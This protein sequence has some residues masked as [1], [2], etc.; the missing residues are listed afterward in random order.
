[1][2]ASILLHL[3]SPVAAL[4]QAAR[5]TRGTMVVA[6]PWALGPERLHDNIMQIFPFGDSGRWTVWWQIS[7]GA[8]V[9]MLHTMGFR[10]AEVF[11]HTQ[12]HQFGHVV[13]AAYDDIHMYTVVAQRGD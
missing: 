3:R 7:A 10:R 8:V 5:R 4:E 12:K 1:V 2:V 9:Q 11:E 13:D 6:E